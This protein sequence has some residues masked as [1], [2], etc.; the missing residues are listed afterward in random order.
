MI[1]SRFDGDASGASCR[2]AF[3]GRLVHLL[4][5]GDPQQLQRLRIFKLKQRRGIV[6]RV[7]PDKQSA[8]CRGMFKKDTDISLF[9]NLKARLP[10]GPIY[11]LPAVK[12]AAATVQKASS[13]ASAHH[14]QSRKTVGD[15]S[16]AV[17]TEPVVA[18]FR[19]QARKPGRMG[20]QQHHQCQP[21]TPK[22]G[23][24]NQPRSSASYPTQTN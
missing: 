11:E 21:T 5:T 4:D 14:T 7:S 9:S 13:C 3:Y 2:Q 15:I 19:N 20:R 10:L 16:A 12:F 23:Q 22:N 17:Y 18:G 24:L 8:V 6:E 1:G